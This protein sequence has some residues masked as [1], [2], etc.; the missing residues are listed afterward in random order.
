[1]KEKEELDEL[2]VSLAP[3]GRLP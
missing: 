2:G 1:D 3:T